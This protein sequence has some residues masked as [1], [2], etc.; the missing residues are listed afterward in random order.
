LAPPVNRRAPVAAVDLATGADPVEFA[1][2]DPE[3]KGSPFR[4]GKHQVRF[5]RV[6]PLPQTYQSAD[7][8]PHLDF[9]ITSFGLSHCHVAFRVAHSALAAGTDPLAAAGPN[10]G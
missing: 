7:E 3:K 5:S 8:R 1:P 9:A 6:S 10:C 4:G 2:L